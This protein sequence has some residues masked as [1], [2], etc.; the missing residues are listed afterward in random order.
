[1]D[2]KPHKPVR[3][4][5]LTPKTVSVHTMLAQ[6][7]LVGFNRI[8]LCRSGFE[9]IRNRGRETRPAALVQNDSAEQ[10]DKSEEISNAIL[11]DT[12]SRGRESTSVRPRT[13]TSRG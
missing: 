6:L 2:T 3:E 11:E 7:E 12:G 10:P 4:Q 9:V 13:C 1:M 5:P 8:D